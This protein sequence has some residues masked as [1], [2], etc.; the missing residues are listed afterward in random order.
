MHILTSEYLFYIRNETNELRAIDPDTQ[1][2]IPN[3][4]F[5]PNDYGMDAIPEGMLP[6][7][8]PY[9]A[10]NLSLKVRLKPLQARFSI[11]FS[12]FSVFPKSYE[13]CY[14]Y[15]QV[16]IITIMTAIMCLFKRITKHW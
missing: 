6:P 12:Q 2:T 7:F 10:Y 13:N 16:L 15:Y 3:F 4:L 8:N 14:Y 9:S 11:D 1:E 5:Q